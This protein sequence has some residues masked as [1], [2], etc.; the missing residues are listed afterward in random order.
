VGLSNAFGHASARLPGTNAFVIDAAQLGLAEASTLLVLDTEGACCQATESP[1]A[2]SGYMRAYTPRAC[3]RSGPRIR[4]LACASPRSASRTA[5]C[6]TRGN[7]R[8]RSAR[9]RPHRPGAL[10]RPGQPPQVLRR[11]AVMMRGHITPPRRLRSATIAACYLEESAALRCACSRRREAIRPASG[12]HAQA[13]P[14][15][16]RSVER[17]AAREYFAA[18]TGGPPGERLR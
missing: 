11:N 17:R 5:W 7:L 12:L 13:L 1:T 8:R 6:T 16:T 4:R 15:A 9:I 18:V 3:Q 14:L 2:S 10:R